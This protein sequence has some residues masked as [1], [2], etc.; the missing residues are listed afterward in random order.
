MKSTQ[1][2]AD[3]ASPITE[4]SL[5]AG[6]AILQIMRDYG[7]NRHFLLPWIGLAS[8]LGIA[9]QTSRP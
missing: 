5:S 7:C 9:G 3:H 6:D 8:D 1:H 4:S 2:A